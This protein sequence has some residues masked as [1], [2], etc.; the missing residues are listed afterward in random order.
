M[1]NKIISNKKEERG[2]IMPSLEQEKF[3][4]SEGI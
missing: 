2:I 1:D 4:I 3:S